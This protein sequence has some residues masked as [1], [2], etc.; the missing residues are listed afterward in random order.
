[1]ALCSAIDLDLRWATEEGSRV[2]L[3]ILC[4]EKI[5]TQGVDLKPIRNSG[6]LNWVSR[7]SLS[8]TGRLAEEILLKSPLN[9]DF[10]YNFFSDLVYKLLLTNQIAPSDA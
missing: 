10:N 7:L 2:V 3:P 4:S 9:V 8:L 6:L 5:R 1:M